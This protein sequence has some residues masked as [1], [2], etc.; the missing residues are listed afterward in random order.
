MSLENNVIEEIHRWSKES[1]EKPNDHYNGLPACPFAKKT[2][3]DNK[4]HFIY[5]YD[6]DWS[7]LNNCINDWN[8]NHDVVV[9]IDFDY[10]DIDDLY[11]LMAKY[12]DD[13]SEGKYKTKDMFLMGFH[14]EADSNEM[15]ED[16]FEMTEDNSYAMIFLQRLSKLQEASN[17]LR[18]KGYY[19]NCEEYYGSESLYQYRRDLYRRLKD[20]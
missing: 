18:E 2:W 8:D 6:E 14:P 11:D 16:S 17:L 9:L 4:I 13:L 7:V 5:K 19:E 12:N 3:S 10:P 1:L 15:L 20:G